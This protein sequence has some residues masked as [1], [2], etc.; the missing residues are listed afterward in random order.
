MEM[1]SH[2]LPQ[3]LKEKNMESK[4]GASLNETKPPQWNLPPLNPVEGTLITPVLSDLNY[5]YLQ[6]LDIN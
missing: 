5:F 1:E 3:S 2:G 6:S 4:R